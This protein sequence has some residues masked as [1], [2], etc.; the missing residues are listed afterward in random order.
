MTTT[1]QVTFNVRR[2]NPKLGADLARAVKLG[3]VF[4][5][6]EVE[7][8][9]IQNAIKSLHE[10]DT[11][12]PGGSAN[13]VPI[14][15]RRDTWTLLGKGHEKTTDGVAGV[16]PDRWITWVV[17]KHIAT[18]LVLVRFN[19]QVLSSAWST[20]KTKYRQG[21][22]LKHVAALK[23]LTL[24]QSALR[25]RL[26]V[27]G[28][29]INRHRHHYL[30]E[31]VVYDVPKTGGTHGKA[32]YD[33]LTHIADPRITTSKVV[34]HR[35]F[36]SDHEALAVTYT[37]DPTPVVKAPPRPKPKPVAAVINWLTK[38]TLGKDSSGRPLVVDRRTLAKLRV[39]EKAL[40]FKFT[41]VQGSYRG[42]GGAEASAGTHDMG[43]VIDLR[44][45]NLP[46][47]ITP[48]EAVLA[49]RKAG[50]IAWHRTKADGF[51]PHI[52]CIDYGNPRLA[53]SA[54]R[55]VVAWEHG[56]N[57]L[58][59]NR[60]DT[61]PRVAIPKR[62]PTAKTVVAAVKAWRVGIDGVDISHHQSHKID[63]AAA[64]R[65][66]VK[67]AYLK[68]TEGETVH[69]D[70]Y[71]RR[72]T[73]CAKAG[74]VIGA[75]HFARP[76]KSGRDGTAEAKMFLKWA[77]VKPGDML[78]VLDLE[79]NGG[80]G[81]AALTKWVG[82]FWGEVIR[83]TGQV[84]ITYT[85]KNFPLNNAF[86]SLLWVPRYN[87]AMRL[88]GLPAPWKTWTIWQFSNGQDGIP[89]TVPGI[90]PCDINTLNRGVVLADLRL[91]PKGSATRTTP[92]PPVQ[93]PVVVVK[94]TPNITAALDPRATP[95]E[96]KA[97]LHLVSERG[98]TPVVRSTAVEGIGALKTLDRVKTVL[99][100]NERKAA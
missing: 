3:D 16:T 77:K 90:G 2:D 5:W 75:Y 97:A 51:D 53:P 87:N 21:E 9:A 94:P 60:A 67:F 61:G 85:S 70:F 8:A 31:A 36:A 45:W 50:L 86:G 37:L 43:G 66:G 46:A 27:G 17:L 15:W 58:K 82:D 14:S 35:G 13:A 42:N 99:A 96:V 29:D 39:A 23:R 1:T 38:V 81:R 80:L 26:V 41:I 68:A 92:T 44:V 93:R 71:A 18:G 84:G 32:L 25:T 74:I 55:Q 12:W 34:V 59:N 91:K 4:G 89:R 47:S 19:T 10:V 40:G 98:D 72:R 7:T 52:H 69:D 54:A 100:A 48:A 24:A 63:W 78:P 57:G 6:Q 65:A 11:Y 95:A 28:G 56:K 22:W 49:L 64:K 76:N 20:H 73:E 79:D 88:P 30:G 62:V 33:Y 83:Q